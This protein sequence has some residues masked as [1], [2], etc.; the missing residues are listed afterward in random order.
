MAAMERIFVA[1]VVVAI[2]LAA[3]AQWAGAGTVVEVGDVGDMPAGAYL[4]PGGT[5]RVEGS[6]DYD[7]DLYKFYWTGGDFHANTVDYT[8]VPFT[9]QQDCEL[10]LFYSDGYGVVA[11]N[12]AWTGLNVPA[13]SAY[14]YVMGLAPGYYYLGVTIHNLEPVDDSFW[15]TIFPTFPYVS[16]PKAPDPLSGPLAGWGNDELF[17]WTA[18]DYVI[19]FAEADL[20][21]GAAGT[22]HPTG[23]VPE[24]ATLSLLA[25]GLGGLAIRRRRR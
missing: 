19:H 24:P 23:V 18:G 14:V 2:G 13:G 6:L 4:L 3:A 25:L 11:N 10:F 22:T 5:D 15:Y 8:A 9:A 21:T 12:D 7:A 20:I 1:A 17:S 16:E